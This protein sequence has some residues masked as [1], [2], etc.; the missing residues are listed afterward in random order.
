MTQ[1][2]TQKKYYY[3]AA[4]LD[5]LNDTFWRSLG[6][7]EDENGRYV[8]EDRATSSK[9]GFSDLSGG[10]IYYTNGHLDF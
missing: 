4:Y 7:Q 2:P 3:D 9:Y 6:S 10:V 5:M 8:D 1:P